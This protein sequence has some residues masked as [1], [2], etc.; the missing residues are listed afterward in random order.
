MDL[1]K[2][3]LYAACIAAA[4][5]IS[6]CKDDTDPGDQTSD[7]KGLFINEVCTGGGKDWIEFYNASDTEISLAGMHVQ[8]NKGN[9]NEY[10][11]P[12]G[13]SINAKG[14]YV[15]EETTD[16]SF[17][18]GGSGDEVHLLDAG[19]VPV[20]EI[21][22][23]AMEDFWTYSRTIDGGDAWDTVYGGTRGRSNSGTPDTPETGDE[24][25]TDPSADYGAI[26][27]NE[28]NGNDKFI[29]LYNSS[30]K[31]INIAGMYI[32][33]DEETKF[34]APGNTVIAAHGFLTVWSEKAV[35]AGTAGQDYPYI[36]ES[37]LSA[38]KSVKIEI[39]SPDGTS[40]D[41]FENLSVSLGETWGENDGKYD[42]S[43]KGSFARDT[44]GSGRWYIMTATEGE[45]NNG[46]VKVEQTPIE[47]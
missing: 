28:I 45:S 35:E 3:I 25:E 1:K 23:P 7:I 36:L 44:D 2:T 30:D 39:F 8:D 47:W 13:A 32:D 46:A 29:E 37:G 33:K 17:G 21:V 20:D 24:P 43:D 10:T 11:F 40:I 14:Y 5:A 9:E 38:D 19:Y 6:G 16:F 27:L 15:V 34:T 12:D 4:A 31:D 18:L 26:R 41:V 22:V 42:S